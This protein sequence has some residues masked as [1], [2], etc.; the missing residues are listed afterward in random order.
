[1]IARIPNYVLTTFAIVAVIILVGLY[2]IQRQ[3]VADGSVGLVVGSDDAGPLGRHR[4]FW[5][6]LSLRPEMPIPVCVSG[7]VVH[8]HIDS[9]QR[10]YV[11]IAFDFS[12]NQDHQK[13]V[14]SQILGYIELQQELQ[15][16]AKAHREAPSPNAD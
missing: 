6:R 7:K 14:A 9:S 10:T 4:V 15:R 16:Q 2:D 8:T 1:M 3:P 5:L 13:L 11:G 12:F